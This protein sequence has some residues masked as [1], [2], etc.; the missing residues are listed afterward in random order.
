MQPPSEPIKLI[1]FELALE[2]I[3]DAWGPNIYFPSNTLKLIIFISLAKWYLTEMC[4]ILF[5]PGDGMAI[6]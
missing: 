5:Y 6:Y 4:F 3:N 1:V 2:N